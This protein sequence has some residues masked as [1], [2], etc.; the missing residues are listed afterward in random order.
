MKKIQNIAKKID[1]LNKTAQEATFKED[2]AEI[3]KNFTDA[4]VEILGADFG[5][6]THRSGSGK[7]YKIVHSTPGSP[8]KPPAMKNGNNCITIP[9][10]YG[11]HMHGSIVLCYNK[12]HTFTPEELA[13]SRLVGTLAAKAVTIPWLIE[14][15]RKALGMAEKQREIEVL[16]SQEK[17]KSEF[18][19]NAAHELRTP[20]AIMKGN[21]DLALMDKDNLKSAQKALKEVNNEIRVLSEILENL[22]LINAARKDAKHLLSLQPT[23]LSALVKKTAERMKMV[24]KD[25]KI[26]IVTKIER[27][28]LMVLGDRLY[29]EKLFL[30]LIKNAVA[31]GKTGGYVKVKIYQEKSLAKVEVA[32]N[33][34][35]ISKE[36]FLRVFERF[37]RGDKAHTAVGIHSGLGL[38]I[39]KWAAE[40]HGGDI[41]VKSVFGKGSTFTV[42]L[43][44]LKETK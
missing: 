9:I 21:V 39:A 35:G 33:G 11:E 44:L 7:E 23:N 19:E 2:R 41:E 6:A 30:N 8:S 12:K 14:N 42:T 16:W 17:I 24:A 3:L 22:M 25:K 1:L 37:Y 27:K 4:G 31:Y 40:T 20:L 32:D 18:T 15:E 10:K 26:K 5:Y 29:L 43:P 34:V 38:P 36:D 13:L 28:A